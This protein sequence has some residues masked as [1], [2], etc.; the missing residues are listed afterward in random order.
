MKTLLLLFA[1]APG[2]QAA[3]FS[4]SCGGDQVN[5]LCPQT[6]TDK[7]TVTWSG[8]HDF[9]QN[10]VRISSGIIWPDLTVSTS[11]AGGGGGSG[12][13][14]ADAPI[15]GDGTAGDHLR[16]GNPL[17]STTVN[18]YLLFNSTFESVDRTFR[19][20]S[21]DQYSRTQLWMYGPSSI[22]RMGSNSIDGDPTDI[23]TEG[24]I[25]WDTVP[26]TG[27]NSGAR[28]KGDRFGLTQ[29]GDSSLYYWRADRD[30]M[31]FQKWDNQTPG[32]YVLIASSANSSVGVNIAGTAPAQT[33]EVN[34]TVRIGSLDDYGL[35][36]AAQLRV[37]ACGGHPAV[38]C[39]VQ[40]SDDFDI[41]TSTSTSGWRNTRT[42]YGP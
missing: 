9:K 18:G 21:L 35:R 6:I 39:R 5:I 23:K 34:G 42:G 41:Y 14:I 33:L 19:L 29:G 3:T 26:G 15:L 24:A 38:Q 25:F 12:A 32:N 7:S 4:T 2:A 28:I 27:R 16:L 11:A 30:R 10:M 40:N 17:S 22:L 20:N 36:T 37:L 31:F 13:V 8:T 1:L